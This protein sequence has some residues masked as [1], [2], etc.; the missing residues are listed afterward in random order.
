[1]DILCDE[2]AAVTFAVPYS[3][4]PVRA[5][6]LRRKAAA[7]HVSSPPTAIIENEFGSGV[8]VKV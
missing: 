8:N 5:R 6:R 3:D 7:A 2:R 1:M 4:A